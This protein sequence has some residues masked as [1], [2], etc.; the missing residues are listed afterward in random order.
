MQL[1]HQF[2]ARQLGKPQ[3]LFGHLAMGHILAQGNASLNAWV[4]GLLPL[5][6]TSTI[7]D[8]GCG[9][10]AALQAIA[11]QTPSGFAVGLDYA[12]PMA[13]QAYRRNRQLIRTGHAGIV[14]G[15]AAMLPFRD[16]AFNIVYAVN[17]IYFWP[18]VHQALR[19]IWRILQPGGTLALGTRPQAQVE[20]LAFMRHGLNVFHDSEIGE[21]LSMMGFVAV[22][23]HVQPDATG[24]GAL[25]TLGR[26][27]EAMSG[28]GE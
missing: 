28:G 15:D 27:P 8:L 2:I 3:G 10:G 20:H 17:V 25:C 13:R 23:R 19:E 26:R 4:R 22:E 5:Q 16:Q 6:P 7:L 12:S 18:D 1:I 21:L 14:Q 9:P 11:Q 24:L